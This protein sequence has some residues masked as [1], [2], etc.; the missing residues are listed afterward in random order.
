MVK[1]RSKL[2]KGNKGMGRKMI[3]NRKKKD[4]EELKVEKGDENLKERDERF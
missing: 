4:K 2:K 3:K 1:E